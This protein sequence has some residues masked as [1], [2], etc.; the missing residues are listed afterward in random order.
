MLQRDPDGRVYRVDDDGTRT[1]MPADSPEA[2]LFRSGL[3]HKVLYEPTRT[4]CGLTPATMPH[5]GHWA[6]QWALVTCPEC[7]RSRPIEPDPNNPVYIVPVVD[8]IARTPIRVVDVQPPTTIQIGA[9]QSDAGIPMQVQQAWSPWVNWMQGTRSHPPQNYSEEDFEQDYNRMVQEFGSDGALGDLL[10][11]NKEVV[12]RVMMEFARRQSAE[13]A[14][15][16]IVGEY[17]GPGKPVMP[18]SEGRWMILSENL[19]K[20]E[21]E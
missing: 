14:R 20:E 15:T 18:T 9:P 5:T 11:A 6:N 10:G 2:L 13:T 12:R 3:F 17:Y 4:P 16:T 7:L 8:G 19:D 1:E 21:H